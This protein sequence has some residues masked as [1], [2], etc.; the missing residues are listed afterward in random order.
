MIS[1]AERVIIRYRRLGNSS[2]VESPIV[3]GSYS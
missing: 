1:M 2:L 3:V